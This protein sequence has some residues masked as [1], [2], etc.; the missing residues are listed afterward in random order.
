MHGCSNKA[1][2]VI[3]QIICENKMEYRVSKSIHLK[4]KFIRTFHSTASN[5]KLNSN[6]IEVSLLNPWFI[7]GFTDGEGSFMISF[8][9]NPN[10]NTG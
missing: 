9:K 10:L 2:M 8:F 3:S 7:T 1:R 4:L 6:N 5:V